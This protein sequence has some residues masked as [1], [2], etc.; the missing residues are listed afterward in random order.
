ME[1]DPY[2]AA[3]FNHLLDIAVNPVSIRIVIGL[4]VLV[5]LLLISAMVSGSEVAYFA[6][7][8]KNLEKLKDKKTGKSIHV[9]K[10]LEKPKRLLATILITNNFVNVGIVILFSFIS[11]SLFTFSNYPILGFLIE[12]VFIT[13]IILLFGEIIPKIYST[14]YPL[15][16]ALQTALPL[17]FF[18]KLFSPFSR[19]LVKTT[20]FANKKIQV[21]RNIS[22]DE[23]SDALSIAGDDL[24]EEERLLKGIVKFSRTEVC[25]I[26]T[27]RLDVVAISNQSGYKKL[28]AVI[29][30]TGLSRIPVYEESFDVVKGIM[31]VKDLLPYLDESDAFDWQKL[32]R[33][34]YFVPESK[35]I[36]DLLG[37]FQQKK[38]HMA[39]IIDEYGG[40]SGVVTLEDILEEI[41]GEINDE[42]DENVP[43]FQRIDEKTY[44]FEGKTLLNDFYRILNEEEDYFDQLKG[45]ADSLAGLIL[46]NKGEMPAKG[47]N[48]ILGKYNFGIKSVDNRRIKQ[49][50]VKVIE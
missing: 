29:Q 44:L 42:S 26:M 6:L 10:L 31:Y 17:T 49:I 48:I 25:E 2:G 4:A 37:E 43:N 13:L 33:E 22:I 9:L 24:K 14:Q 19:A 36:D 21:K 41:V 7:S 39:L 27:P 18:S 20:V 45:D 50:I 47:E 28:L 32:I 38:I 34:P 1:D 8:P 16:F 35:K 5:V 12:V 3:V 11:H 23:L 46:E 15:N 40:V 30:E